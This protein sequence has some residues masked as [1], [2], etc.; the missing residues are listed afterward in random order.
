M[1][2]SVMRDKARAALSE[3]F[4]MWHWTE[5]ERSGE[6]RCQCGKKFGFSASAIEHQA[7]AVIEASLPRSTTRTEYGVQ[8]PNGNVFTTYTEDAAIELAVGE[9]I[10]VTRQR[11]QFT[12]IHTEW[13]EVQ[14]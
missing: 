7:A 1:S 2:E 8:F 4:V 12:D 3:H 11:T 13:T 9:D 6:W 14:Q 5:P 10:P